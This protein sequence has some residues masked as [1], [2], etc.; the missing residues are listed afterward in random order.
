MMKKTYKSSLL[1][2]SVLASF[3]SCSESE[4]LQQANLSKDK[5][6]FH[7]T[8]DNSWKPLSPASSSRA[9]IAAA[10]EK[11]PIVVPTPF[12]KPLYLHPVVQDGIHIWSKEGKP[13]TRSGAP[14][15]D[16][17]HER[18]AQT[19]GTMSTKTDLSDYRSFGVTAIYKNG[20]NNVS[21]FQEENGDPKIA[22]ATSTTEDKVWEIKDSRWPVGSEVSFHAF[23]PYSAGSTSPLSFTPDVDGEKTQIKY[24]ALTGKEEIKAQ[25]DLIL[26]TAKGSQSD[27]A[28]KLDFYH[29]LTA[30]SFA[31]DGNLADVIG[32][33]GQL[34]S[35]S[36]E[37]VCTEGVCT[38]SVTDGTP[39][40]PKLVW[41]YAQNEKGE[42]KKGNY[43][44]NLEKRTIDLGKSQPLTDDNQTLMMIPQN[45][46]GVT[47]NFTFKLNNESQTFSIPLKGQEWVAGTSVVYK[48]SADVFNSIDKVKVTYASLSKEWQDAGYPNCSFKEGDEIGLYVVGKENKVIVPN[49]KL[50]KKADGNWETDNKKVLKVGD[51]KYFIYYPYVDTNTTVDGTATDSETF[52]SNK[53]STWAP[54]TDQSDADR[55]H[56]ADLQ[57]AMGAIGADGSSLEF[58][59]IRQLGL[60]IMNLKDK[61]VVERR[62]FK[63]TDFTYYYPELKEELRATSAPDKSLYTDSETEPSQTVYASTNFKGH[64]PYKSKE[65]LYMQIIKPSENVVFV[66]ADETGKPRSGW[67]ALYPDRSTFSVTKNGAVSKDIYSDADFYYLTCHLTAKDKYDD[68][69]TETFTVPVDGDYKLQCWGAAGA[70]NIGKGGY[71]EGHKDYVKNFTLYICV[72]GYANRWN[73]TPRVLPH[74]SLAAGGGCTSITTT[75]R[76]DGQLREYELVKFTDVVLVAGG[77]GAVDVNGTPGSAGGLNGQSSSNGAGG[78]TQKGG[79]S[80]VSYAA[81][82]IWP[83][84]FGFGGNA[85]KY[86]GNNPDMGP[87][88]GGGW[89]GGGGCTGYG[90][91]GGGSSYFSNNSNLLRDGKTIAGYDDGT[92]KELQPTPDGNGT[93]RGQIGHGVCII[94]QTSFQ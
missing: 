78:G 82:W 71:V 8:L 6:T 84:G 92:T 23:A 58:G 41:A 63:T 43:S 87:L 46:D 64:S 75:K 40:T 10:T 47:L 76:G 29:A 15:E 37:N 28:V 18:V 30:V 83:G 44:F 48:L 4:S 68:N 88:G 38:L 27:N 73:N 31:I 14:L 70:S 59:M 86:N 35:V 77:G 74:T 5:I 93:Q 57:V 3:T 9:A 54:N 85:S 21:L 19:R 36:L 7:A 24:I 50:T 39:E 72:G 60:A 94:T 26:A 65:N 55:I 25:P 52:F 20:E 91:S 81:Y 51:F 69:K 1:A 66:A 16:V 34:V 12:G 53:I 56:K 13:I 89:Y 45:L 17:E 42:I 33:G 67:G 79:G 62:T 61:K 11:G 32:D 90:S 22:V 80:T 49:L 2:L